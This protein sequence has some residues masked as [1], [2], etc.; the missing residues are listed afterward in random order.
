M[1]S[2]RTLAQTTEGKKPFQKQKPLHSLIY[3]SS[4]EQ[5]IPDVWNLH[6]NEA[7]EG[8]IAT[9]ISPEDLASILPT[10]QLFEDSALEAQ[11][12]ALPSTARQRGL[13]RV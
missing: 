13:G 2:L 6:H 1:Y 8:R 9:M 10:K 5:L 4:A 12:P 7:S 11:P 3:L